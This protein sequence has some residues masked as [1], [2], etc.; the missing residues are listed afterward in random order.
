MGSVAGSVFG[1]EH[2]LASIHA[3]VEGIPRGATALL[4]E[5]EAGVGKTTL[6]SEAVRAAQERGWRVLTAS[7]AEQEAGLTFAVLSDLLG[8]A[9]DEVADRLPPPLRRAIDVALLRAGSEGVRPDRRA[10]ALAVTETIRYL[11]DSANLLL[12]VDDVQ[13][14]D[15]SSAQAVAFAIRRL[16]DV[17]VGVIAALR[18]GSG[19]RDRF[20]L[21]RAFPDESLQRVG[22]GPLDPTA[23]HRLLRRRSDAGA[24]ASFA[25]RL[26]EAS[27]GN[28]FFALEL[29]RAADREGLE[30][31]PGAPLPLPRDL[32]RLLGGRI[33]LLSPQASDLVLIV[34][35]AGRPVAGLI[36]ELGSSAEAIE[37]ALHEAEGAE[38]IE[39]IA[40]RLRFTH[41]LLGSAVYA[42][43]RP[44][45][46]REA[47]RRL[48]QVLED[49]IERAWHLALSTEHADPDVSSVLD[50]ASEVAESRGAPAV[51]AQLLELA[52][53]LTPPAE[54]EAARARSIA[55][56]ERLFE[57]GDTTGATARMEEIVAQAPPGPVRAEAIHR[58]CHL[59]WNDVRRVRELVDVALQEAGDEAPPILLANLHRAMG[60]V[61]LWGGDS[62]RAVHHL[63]RA[64]ALAET[65]GD[66]GEIALCLNGQAYLGF[67][68]GRP[69]A[70]ELIRRAVLLEQP[71]GI[72]HDLT[73]PLRTLGML[74][75]WAG[76]LDR[77]RMELERD[78]RQ[79][80][81]RGHLGLLWDNLSIL[82]EL[83]VRAGNWELAERYAAEGLDAVTDVLH[84]QAREVLLWSSALVA[85]HRGM[86]DAARSYATEGLLLAERHEDRW[87]VFANGSVLGF[88]EL[89]LGNAEAAHERLAPLVE[90]AERMGL[91]EPGIFPF[92][93]DEIEALIA[94][95]ELDEAEALLGRLEGQAR[96]RD[97]ALAL[98]G[99]ARC[100]CLLAAARGDL[101]RALEAVGE[102]IEHHRRVPQPFDLAR[103]Q[104]VQGQV[105]RR[106]KRKRPARG[107][108]EGALETFE[109]LGAPIWAERT[110]VELG[111]I[112]GRASSPTGLTP[113]ER[114][115]AG[116]VARGMT[117]RAVAAALFVS[118]STVRANLK[119]IYSKLGI[120]SRTEL[121]ARLGKADGR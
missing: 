89:S 95:G 2:E 116:L 24:S 26:H 120:R 76:D 58:L 15:A 75:L 23:L 20:E 81:E 103:T 27:G 83:E 74:H 114:E 115:V 28:P 111:R 17:P 61:E 64:L 39:T 94:L 66:P 118:E 48:S 69:G 90:L 77:A 121:A 54:T 84:E 68:T 97:R 33:R 40:G 31:V 22:V 105:L 56:A 21:D 1:R 53:R 108:L 42:D 107:V 63:D 35:A 80:V 12:A 34:A 73:H 104:L 44:D 43:A 37:A 32:A 65:T 78:Y 62:R 87:Y 93:P 106:L 60:W 92:L 101:D 100:R 19:L 86:A 10:V 41:P 82:T 45:K 70:L 71:R 88:L 55:A 67:F 119:H 9:L 112:G 85:A 52:S 102:A 46:Q 79:V 7:A 50:G 4:I 98:A 18:A 5:G 49:P 6:W 29:A 91:E 16:R 30:P 72:D 117:N 25:L 59:E 51:A 14:V 8:D 96:A 110:R 38:L 109:R 11:A 99:A 113:T 57:A 36:H 47:H 13:W 3:F